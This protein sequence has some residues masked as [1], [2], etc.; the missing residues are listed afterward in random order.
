MQKLLL[1]TLIVLSTPGLA[2][3]QDAWE[4]I[5]VDGFGSVGLPPNME[6][7]NDR[8][9]AAM[10]GK[11]GAVS[12]PPFTAI[13]QQK[14]LNTGRPDIPDTYVSFTIKTK[15][16]TS[17]TYQKLTDFTLSKSELDAINEKNKKETYKVASLLK[18]EILK[19]YPAVVATY[20]GYK[21]VTMQY[22]RKKEGE[23]PVAV[24]ICYIYN[25]DRR[26]TLV[27]AYKLED[28]KIWKPTFK[29]I[30]KSFKIDV[31]NI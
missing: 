7:Q 22:D 2:I 12:A 11:K 9:R 6:V 19:W 20:S 27:F 28:K 21:V 31:R 24:E 15:I 23:S 1:F 3:S 14:N 10:E 18:F 16:D 17:G 30:K 26:H 29:K 5:S 25:D 8:Y 13:F 4:T